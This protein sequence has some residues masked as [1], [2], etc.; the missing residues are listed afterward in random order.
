MPTGY[1]RVYLPKVPSSDWA[2]SLALQD[3]VIGHLGFS[4]KL[5]MPEWS[6][7]VVDVEL[8]VEI[9]TPLIVELMPIISD[10]DPRKSESAN[11]QFSHK[12]PSCCLNNLCQ[13]LRFNWLGAVVDYCNQKLPLSSR[14]W[15]QSKDVDSLQSEWVGGDN[16]CGS[17]AS[18][19]WILAYFWHRSHCLTNSIISCCKVGQLYPCRISLQVSDLPLKW[20]HIFLRA[21][22][23]VYNQLQMILNTEVKEVNKIFYITD[24]FGEY[25]MKLIF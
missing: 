5:W 17:V 24:L 16:R 19:L 2:W 15:E 25:A 22:P 7:P 3:S 11:D 4:I 1:Y 8:R 10:D 9:F 23:E 20:F 12:V 18:F 6:E 14:L 21:L 13:G